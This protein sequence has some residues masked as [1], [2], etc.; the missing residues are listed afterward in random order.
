[1]PLLVDNVSAEQIKSLLG[2]GL[3]ELSSLTVIIKSPWSVVN[4]TLSFPSTCIKYLVF[5]NK[6][7]NEA[8]VEEPIPVE[9]APS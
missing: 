4:G 2:P 7:V 8:E 5:G 9:E 1:L 6:Q 3:P